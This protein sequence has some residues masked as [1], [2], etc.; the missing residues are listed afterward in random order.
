MLNMPA[1]T[2]DLSIVTVCVQLTRS[3]RGGNSICSVRVR[4]NPS[5]R[6]HPI[7]ARGHTSA[8]ALLRNI[9]GYAERHGYGVLFFDKNVGESSDRHVL[10]SKIPALY[11]A[12][13][14]LSTPYLWWQDADSLFVL[15]ERSLEHLKPRLPKSLTI[16]GDHNCYINSGHFML[17]NSS[18]TDQAPMARAPIAAAVELLLAPFRVTAWLP[19]TTACRAAVARLPSDSVSAE[20]GPLPHAVPR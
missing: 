18:W 14:H 16:A 12:L 11:Y 3:F 1:T 17:R 8:Q 10:W 7:D 5:T 4:S 9:K 2:G 15:P 6:R 19:C 13:A 20:L